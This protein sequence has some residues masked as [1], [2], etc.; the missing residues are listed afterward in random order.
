[1][2]DYA[3]GKAA[4]HKLKK[5]GKAKL[6]LSLQQTPDILAEVGKR[7]RRPYVVG[8]AAETDELEKHARAKLDK[9]HLDLVAA[10]WVGKGR[11][12]DRDD[13]ALS[14]YWPGGGEEF[15]QA[16]KL[17]LARRLI[18]LIAARYAK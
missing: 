9:K 1:M 15:G 8:F 5:Q 3:P 4:P 12:F 6:A 10:N 11:G 7:A 18:A 17:D 2:A 16:T 13:N 14:V